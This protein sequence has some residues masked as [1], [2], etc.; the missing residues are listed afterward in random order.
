MRVD[1][2]ADALRDATT[3]G[4][5]SVGEQLPTLLADGVEDDHAAGAH[6]AVDLTQHVRQPPTV[7]A[8]KDGVGSG[9]VGRVGLHE[10]THHRRD[11]RRPE[12]SA[13]GGEDLPTAGADLECRD[14]EVRELQPRLDGHRAGAE[15]DVPQRRA[16][17]QVEH[18]EREQA[19]G[20][21]GDHLHAAVKQVEL[22]LGDT[23]RARPPADAFQNQV[24]RVCER[25]RGG[26]GER[27]RTDALVRL[28]AEA[29]ASVHAVIVAVA[30]FD[31]PAGDHGGCLLA[32]GEDAEERPPLDQRRVE[33]VPRPAG[34]RYGDHLV[35]RHTESVDKQ[36]QRVERGARLD[37]GVGE[38]AAKRDGVTEEKR[39][40]GG[41]DDDVAV[42]AVLLEDAIQ[43][44]RDV[45]PHGAL[46]EPP[47]DDLAVA[48]SAGE[49]VSAGDA[50]AHRGGQLDVALVADT[51]DVERASRLRHRVPG[52]VAPRR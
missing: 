2:Q 27:K 14:A 24:V 47:T 5:E 12:P 11:T 3:D 40:A 42:V 17:V 49:D 46:G 26:F 19:H 52:A 9:Q 39:V 23:E 30:V 10:V 6:H 35:I 16:V 18:A 7:T 41:K 45:D 13:V 21:L 43:G 1:G 15:A 25:G 20:P 34:E 33:V 28:V 51:D 38:D 8:D 37:R 4:G 29:L 36:L 32:V 48:A 31:H 50:F 44:H 22:A